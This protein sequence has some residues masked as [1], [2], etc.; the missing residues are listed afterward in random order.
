MS[1][2]YQIMKNVLECSQICFHSY[3][4]AFDQLIFMDYYSNSISSFNSIFH[5][6]AN[7]LLHEYTTSFGTLLFP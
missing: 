1:L 4:V 5:S 7:L 3:N 2:P 6:K